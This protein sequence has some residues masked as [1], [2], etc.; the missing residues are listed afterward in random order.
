M[1][2]ATKMMPSLAAL[3]RIDALPSFF[4]WNLLQIG[5]HRSMLSI[6]IR[7]SSNEIRSSPFSVASHYRSHSSFARLP[8]RPPHTAHRLPNRPHYTR[9]SKHQIIQ[10]SGITPEKNLAKHS[11]TE[12]RPADPRPHLTDHI[13]YP[14]AREHS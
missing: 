5:I 11:T 2:I 14:H 6:G 10:L 1:K 8:A 7:A 13:A 3:F 4:N 9:S 12:C